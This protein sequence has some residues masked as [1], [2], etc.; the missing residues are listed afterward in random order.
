MIRVGCEDTREG[1]VL[2]LFGDLTVEHARTLKDLL[3][4]SAVGKAVLSLDLT[5]ITSADGAGLQLICSAH[6][7]WHHEGKRVMLSGVAP[8][9]VRRTAGE[10]GFTRKEGCTKEMCNDCIWLGGDNNE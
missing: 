5:G 10:A 1:A 9:T 3:T 2:K 4:E 6:K 7:A 8:E